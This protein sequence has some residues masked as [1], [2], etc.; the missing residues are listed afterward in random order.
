MEVERIFKFKGEEKDLD[1]YTLT[2]QDHFEVEEIPV[3][4]AEI[5]R[6]EKLNL[7]LVERAEGEEIKNYTQSGEIERLRGIFRNMFISELSSTVDHC[8]HCNTWW[9]TS[10]HEAHSQVNGKPCP[11]EVPK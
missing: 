5:D 6:L 10:K 1:R 8:S 4:Q 3:Q 7:T 9:P 2:I 11:C